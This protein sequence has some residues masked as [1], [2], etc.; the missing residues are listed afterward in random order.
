MS[1]FLEFLNLSLKAKISIAISATK[2]GFA[3]TRNQSSDAMSRIDTDLD[4]DEE[5]DKC[6]LIFFEPSHY[7]P[8]L[9]QQLT[10]QL[11]AY[12]PHLS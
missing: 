9:Q 2:L 10:S 11:V 5:D 8:F 7:M 12:H 1:E 3:Y 4:C 6:K